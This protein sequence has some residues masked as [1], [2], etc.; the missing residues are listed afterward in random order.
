MLPVQFVGCPPEIEQVAIFTGD[1]FLPILGEEGE[2]QSN[3]GHAWR[4]Q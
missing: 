4:W 3:T 2:R 1:K